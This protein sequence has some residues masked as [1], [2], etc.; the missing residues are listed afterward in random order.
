MSRRLSRRGRPLGPIAVAI[1]DVLT[2][3]PMTYREIAAELTLSV[4]A[5]KYTC[6][7]LLDANR[8]RV[9]RRVPVFGSHK[10]IALFAPAQLAAH[11]PLAA[12]PFSATI[13]G[14]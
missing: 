6:T 5:A 3:K 14:G 8:I 13:L 1:L 10:P 2:S 12:T 4:M 9:V 11:V 7:R